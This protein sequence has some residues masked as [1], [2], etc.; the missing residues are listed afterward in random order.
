MLSIEEALNTIPEYKNIFDKW[1]ILFD[2]FLNGNL[3][4][5]EK[6]EYLK[7]KQTMDEIERKYNIV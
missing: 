5:D 1:M 6:Y 4:D 7:I 2:K 3:S